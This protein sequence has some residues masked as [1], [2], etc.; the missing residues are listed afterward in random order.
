MGPTNSKINSLSFKE[1]EF[2]KDGQDG[3]QSLKKQ[4]AR[5]GASKLA[6]QRSRKDSISQ[7]TRGEISKGNRESPGTQRHKDLGHVG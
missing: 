7:P 4:A 1:K 2:Q 3:G 6:S 5:E